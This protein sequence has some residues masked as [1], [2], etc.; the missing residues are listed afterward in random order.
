MS[1]SELIG[2]STKFRAALENP[3]LVA[4]VDSAVLIQGETGTGKEVFART[5]HEASS[6][7]NNP[8]MSLNC[9][10][11]RFAGFGEIRGIRAIHGGR[12][13]ELSPSS[14]IFK[15]LEMAGVLLCLRS[16]ARWHDVVAARS[17]GNNEEYKTRTRPIGAFAL[18]VAGFGFIP[19]DEGAGGRWDGKSYSQGHSKA[20]GQGKES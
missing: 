20:S 16:T 19:T 7:R 13:C 3:G 2:S 11:I 6:R 10:A 18:I 14:F 8:F 1:N 5:I 12:D 9:S 15:N 4:L 17:G